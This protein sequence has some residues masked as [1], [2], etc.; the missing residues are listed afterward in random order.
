[1]WNVDVN[2]RD[3]LS[4]DTERR[5]VRVEP[6]CTMGEITQALIPLGWTLKIVPELDDLTV[7]GLING[8]GVE[9]SSF[10]YGLFQHICSAFE[11]NP[12]AS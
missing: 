12:D 9:T 2:M 4:I 5:V 1:M 8:F 11:V 6:Q 3:I 10:R 7:G